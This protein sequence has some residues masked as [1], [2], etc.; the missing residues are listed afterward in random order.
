MNKLDEAMLPVKL[1]YI[2]IYTFTFYI[3]ILSFFCL[4]KIRVIKK[5]KD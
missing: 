1:K 5:D 4:Q 3:F 2:T